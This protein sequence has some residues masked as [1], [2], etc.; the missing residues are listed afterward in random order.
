MKRISILVI[1]AHCL[2]L[3]WMA[4]WIPVKKMEKKPIVVRSVREPA[5]M[6]TSQASAPSIQTTQQ[7]S[8]APT[9]TTQAIVPPKP[10][11]EKK[12]EVK[13]TSK[14]VKKP[15]TKPAPKP[16]AKAPSPKPK[17]PIVS[18]AL[19][20]QLQESIAKIEGKASAFNTKSNRQPFRGIANLSIDEGS[21]GADGEYEGLL[22]D[23]LQNNLELPS[24]GKVK[25]ALTLNRN[26]K[27]I[28]VKMIDSHSEQNRHFLETALKGISFPPFDGSLKQKQEHTFVISFCNL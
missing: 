12:Q 26:G 6:T 21:Y 20:Q 13:A 11:Q 17:Q 4:L 23:C 14:P 7:T 16:P 22:I 28:R 15:Q 10:K 9:H 1:S 18:N 19:L 25:L 2:I 3:L 8:P 27:C 24:V 5:R